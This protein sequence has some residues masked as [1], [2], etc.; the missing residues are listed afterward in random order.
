MTRPPLWV[1]ALPG[2]LAIGLVVDLS[3]R[4]RVRVEERSRPERVEALRTTGSGAA[5]EPPP[6]AQ[7]AQPAGGIST[8]DSSATE[9]GVDG[10]EYTSLRGNGVPI[11]TLPAAPA[12]ESDS[13][14][15]DVLG[16]V[17]GIRTAHGTPEGSRA[18]DGA[19][20]E[21]APRE[22]GGRAVA[23]SD[24]PARPAAS[25]G[26]DAAFD[27]PLVAALRGG[28]KVAF[29]STWDAPGSRLGLVGEWGA[30]GRCGG[31]AR[32][33][34]EQPVGGR[35]S[36]RGVG[37]TGTG[38]LPV[39][40]LMVPRQHCSAA[41]AFWSV[42]RSPVGPE[43]ELTRSAFAGVAAD[44]VVVERGRIWAASRQGAI[45]LDVA[46]GA[47]RVIWLAA[48]PPGFAM[49]LLGCFR[50]EAFFVAVEEGGSR[51]GG[52]WRVSG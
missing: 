46:G 13:S 51:V 29:Y 20:G 43:V 44:A 36:V 34:Y 1:W 21:P 12:V 26:R 15:G 52:V 2:G 31:F 23:P 32:M 17:A 40:S 50:G 4:S 22:D 33:T 38:G 7:V 49:R 39:V 30:V 27:R 6:V 11:D 16:S 45:L 9:W 18:F 8:M 42:S 47:R 3:V 37:E 48:P 14:P 10:G 5:R 25:I 35:G 41:G 19:F 24:E 28:G